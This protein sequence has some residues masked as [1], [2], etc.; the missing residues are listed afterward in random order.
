M[1][2][3][4]FKE[5]HGDLPLQHHDYERE[6]ANVMTRHVVYGVRM[7]ASQLEGGEV[8]ERI[9]DEETRGD[10]TSGIFV[11]TKS[12]RKR[13]IGAWRF[14]AT[15]MLS[16]S[17][18][19]SDKLE[20]SV[21]RYGDWRVDD[22]LERTEVTYAPC[23]PE[24]VAGGLPVLVLDSQHEDKQEPLGYVCTNTIVAQHLGKAPSSF[25]S[26]IAEIDPEGNVDPDRLARADTMMRV[27][28]VAAA[29][30]GTFAPG[31]AAKAKGEG[32]AAAWCM[33]K[34]PTG[35]GQGVIWFGPSAP[36]RPTGSFSDLDVAVAG[37]GS[38]NFTSYERRGPFHPGAGMAD[39]HREAIN[40]D[41]E[42][43]LPT[44]LDVNALWYRDVLRDAR[45]DFTDPL[46]PNPAEFPHAVRTWLQ[47]HKDL[48]RW[49]FWTGI[50]FQ[51]PVP[52]TDVPIDAVPKSP[53]SGLETQH[54]TCAPGSYGR[55]VLEW[56]VDGRYD[57]RVEV[58]QQ[59]VAY[60]RQ[61]FGQLD[62]KAR[63]YQ[64]SKAGLA[65]RWVGGVTPGGEALL[66]PEL[67]VRHVRAGVEQ[68]SQV[69]NYTIT[70]Y[71]H[72]KS[73]DAHCAAIDLATGQP[74][75]GVHIYRDDSSGD[76]IVKGVDGSGE[77]NKAQP[78]KLCVDLHQDAGEVLRGDEVATNTTLDASM[79]VMRVDTTSGN[80]QINL[81]ANPVAGRTYTIG[82][83]GGS[84]NQAQIS[85]NGN[86]VHGG[87]SLNLADG[88]WTTLHFDG[89]SD[90]FQIATG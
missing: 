30:R 9:I 17:D 29:R 69:G 26:M 41:G 53:R 18:A 90:W 81:P 21:V 2:F 1:S 61:A 51:N 42:P 86:N 89:G 24:R 19:N 67:D 5:A 76:V 11:K 57:Q 77:T 12:E 4:A 73:R 47:Y 48:D 60:H 27:V 8:S 39:K 46:A 33:S 74:V 72:V 15:P 28:S 50:P 68:S 7:K 44:H 3:I 40:S 64:S 6:G 56:K 52:P 79:R 75:D 80:V 70:Y 35:P 31:A 49:I 37:G 25:S 54:E 23:G 71:A 43:M 88:E 66:P 34:S 59:P 85:G 38:V 65:R 20:A 22:R 55:P 83:I 45:L 78:Y 10:I 63:C 16:Y 82:N 13:L 14:G 87:A 36:A 62:G 32:N 84:G 58:K